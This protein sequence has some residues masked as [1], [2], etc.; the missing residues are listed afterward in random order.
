MPGVVLTAPPVGRAVWARPLP[1]REPH[2]GV[3]RAFPHVLRVLLG[4]PHEHLHRLPAL[5]LRLGQAEQRLRLRARLLRHII[6]VGPTTY[7]KQKPIAGPCNGS[8]SGA[9]QSSTRSCV[10]RTRN[11]SRV[12][13]A[14]GM[15]HKQSM[16]KIYNA[17]Y[18]T[19]SSLI[20]NTHKILTTLFPDGADGPP[21]TLAHGC[22]TP[23]TQPF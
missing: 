20:H 22:G 14:D 17:L 8:V 5:R 3:Y 10:V 2:E 6:V 11:V 23:L 1:R 12:T 18:R 7:P 16:D 15:G 21:I 19:V 9:V 4:P 13:A